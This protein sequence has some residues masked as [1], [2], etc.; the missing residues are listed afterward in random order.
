MPCEDRRWKNNSSDH[1]LC[2][3]F[4][5]SLPPQLRLL[6]DLSTTSLLQ[7]LWLRLILPSQTSLAFRN[8]S[9]SLGVVKSFP[10]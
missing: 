5:S 2:C 3:Y 9:G 8:L 4:G 10:P 6:T 1:Q 7:V